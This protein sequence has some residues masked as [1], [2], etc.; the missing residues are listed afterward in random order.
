MNNNYRLGS[1][2]P[3]S[4]GSMRKRLFSSV[5]KQ[6]RLVKKLRNKKKASKKK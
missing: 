5:A 2:F 6:K 1:M 4:N 3:N